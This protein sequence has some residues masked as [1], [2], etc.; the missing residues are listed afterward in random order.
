MTPETNIQ[1][2]TD[3][4]G[5]WPKQKN[6]Q[7]NTFNFFIAHI[8]SFTALAFVRYHLEQLSTK[9]KGSKVLKLNLIVVIDCK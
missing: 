6:K 9:G 2:L 1:G 3:K 4:T 5:R 8:A 7:N